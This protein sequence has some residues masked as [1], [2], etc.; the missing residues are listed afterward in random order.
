MH[1]GK[2][3]SKIQCQM[4]KLFNYELFYYGP[5]DTRTNVYYYF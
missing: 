5:I 1:W 4:Q 3:Y 2:G